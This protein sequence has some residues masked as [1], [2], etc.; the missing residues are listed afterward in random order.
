MDIDKIVEEL[1][2]QLVFSKILMEQARETCIERV[3][4]FHS[5]YISAIE[6]C[7]SLLNKKEQVNDE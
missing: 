2:G 1:E 4:S 6:R 5:G 3:F 7:L